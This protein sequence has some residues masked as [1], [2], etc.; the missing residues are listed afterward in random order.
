MTCGTRVL[1][2]LALAFVGL[3]A[4]HAANLVANPGFEAVGTEEMPENWASRLWTIG[5]KASAKSQVG[6]ASGKRS[7]MLDMGPGKGVFGVFS[8]AV[9]VSD[10]KCKSLLVSCR[11]RTQKGPYAQ[12][13]VVSYADDFMKAEWETRPL[14]SEARN[15]RESTPW[16]TCTWHAELAPEAKQVVVVVQVMTEGKLWLDDV[17]LKPSPDDIACEG[18]EVGRVMAL[19]ATRR[20]TMRLTSTLPGLTKAKV[21]VNATKDG[22]RLATA[23]Q[24]VEL[25]TATPKDVD[26]R[27]NV[28][29][30]DEHRAEVVVENVGSGE[31]SAY[32]RVDCPGLV[33]AYL[34]VP[35]FRGTI[36]STHESPELVVSGRIF[37][38]PG[39]AD[40]VKLYGRL[41]GTGAE[42]TEA[43]G[44]A[45]Q[46][47]GS[48][49]MTLPTEGMLIGKH[50]V[51]VEARMGAAAVATTKLPVFRAKPTAS[52]VTYDAQRRTWMEGREVFPIGIYHVLDPEGLED[53]KAKGFNFA[54]V[55]T[56]KASYVL[57]EAAAAKSM[58]LVIASPSTRRDFWE[59]RE[60]KFGTRPALLAW[61][62]KQRPDAYLIHPDEALALYQILQEVSP[63]HPVMTTLT[64]PDTFAEYARAT[65]IVVPWCL[66]VPQVSVRRVGELV[67]QARLATQGR[68]PVWAMI[69]LAGNAWATD[70]TLDAETT[71]R[72]PTPE[73]VRAMTYLA[74]VHG[75]DGLVYFCYNLQQ[76]QSQDNFRIAQDAPELWAAMPALTA[77]IREITPALNDRVSRVELEDAAEGAVQMA[78]WKRGEGA[79]IIAVNTSPLAT[80][81]SFTVPNSQ[82]TE[83]DVMFDGRKLKSVRPGSFSDR[84]EPFGVNV[85]CTP[86]GAAEGGDAAKGQ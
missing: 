61:E 20:A 33:D 73:E 4:G 64:Y 24:V 55:P 65:D 41:V 15:L 26:V 49:R 22:R 7:L 77:E 75:A 13:M 85:Y 37:A 78:L 57:A 11:Y 18:L 32:S 9:D 10:L 31:L 25:E 40:Q 36:V 70:K 53:V 62:V 5:T 84:F 83:L 12:V 27:Y 3:P 2:M 68:K 60:E 23:S 54:I 34:E 29:A 30:R 69:Q 76:N 8:R 66:P 50:E 45:R 48:F 74:L 44:I 16:T 82:A 21:T 79:V 67:D 42:A 51:A 17:V 47:D 19:P 6:G 59:G 58:G 1:A 80:I 39:I 28:A 14:S 38:A 52:E 81:T 63:T 46:G 43:Q 86:G 71:G 56:T 35:A 72:L